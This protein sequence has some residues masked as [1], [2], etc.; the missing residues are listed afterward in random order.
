MDPLQENDALQQFMKLLGENGREGQA[1]DLSQLMWYM[2][3]MM[4]QFDAVNRELQ[5][6]KQQI[7]RFWGAH[8]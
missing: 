5:E 3:G 4:R 1:A 6:V 7:N 2:D 8:I